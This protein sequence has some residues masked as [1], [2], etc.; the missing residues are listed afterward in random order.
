[1]IKMLILHHDIDI[2]MEKFM[3]FTTNMF[4]SSYLSIEH[5]WF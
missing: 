5:A 3:Y 2:M 1:M 4:S